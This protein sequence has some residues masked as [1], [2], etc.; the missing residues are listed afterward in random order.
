[1][2]GKKNE[3]NNVWCRSTVVGDY[4]RPWECSLLPPVL[5]G[6]VGVRCAAAAR[7]ENTCCVVVDAFSP[8]ILALTPCFHSPGAIAGCPGQQ[9][10]CLVRNPKTQTPLQNM[11]N[12][13]AISSDVLSLF[14]LHFVWDRGNRSRPNPTVIEFSQTPYFCF[15]VWIIFMCED[16]EFVHRVA[17][18]VY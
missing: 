15:V 18:L 10:Y 6:C 9:D 7:C 3:Q 12:I 11:W 13:W 17:F 16:N 14:H 8:K 2:I 5:R 1:M 4:I